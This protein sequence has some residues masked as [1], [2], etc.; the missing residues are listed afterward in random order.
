MAHLSACVSTLLVAA[1]LFQIASISGSVGSTE[2]RVRVCSHNKSISLKVTSTRDQSVEGA[3]DCRCNV[4]PLENSLKNLAKSD[5]QYTPEVGLH[6][7]HLAAANWNDARKMCMDEGGHLAIVN[8]VAEEMV[9]LEMLKSNAE[10]IRGGQNKEEALL[11]IHDLFAEGEWWTVSGEPLR[12]T[13][14][15]N[16][17][18]SYWDGQPDNY[19][20]N[21]NCGALVDVGGM[22]DVFCHDKF[23]FFCEIPVT[24]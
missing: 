13:G 8:S 22:D 5:Y 2:L 4:E 12:A 24:C 6:K 20:G 14:Y 10:G 19:L 3:L 15:V 18:R 9:L 23:A 21:Q 16:W 7:L 1:C 11:G 17:S